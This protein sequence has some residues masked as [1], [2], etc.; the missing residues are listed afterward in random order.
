[1]G[2][3]RGRRDDPGVSDGPSDGIGP[4]VGA[5]PTP[6]PDGHGSA[7]SGR[8]GRGTV[9]TAAQAEEAVRH[10]RHRRP[11][12]HLHPHRRGARPWPPTRCCPSS[13]P[14]PARPV[15]RSR[16]R[17]LPGRAHPRRVRRPTRRRPA[18][19]RHP[20][21]AGRPRPAPEANIIKL[22]NISASI[23]QLKAAIAELQAK[24][25]ASP[26]TPTSPPP[27]TSVDAAARYDKV[28]GSAVNPVLREGNSDRRAPRSVKEYARK[29]H[30]HSMGVVGRLQ[31]QRGHHVLGRLPHNER[32]SP[33]PPPARLRIEH[34]AAETARHG[35]QARL[36]RCWPARSSTARGS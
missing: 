20:R 23:P 4:T 8:Y 25:Y 33:W 21:R 27:T 35:A 7:P 2:N 29:S 36:K 11:E 18:P 13:R 10:D 14:S 1:V 5:G 30:P 32:R 31:D 22:P 3:L 19:A 6:S 9:Q 28:K 24:G 16:R 17:H 15:C 12:D 34:V 26:T